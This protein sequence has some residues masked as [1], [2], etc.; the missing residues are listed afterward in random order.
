MFR[1]P[2]FPFGVVDISAQSALSPDENVM[3]VMCEILGKS[4]QAIS[5]VNWIRTRI[6][7]VIAGNPFAALK[8]CQI[9][10]L[11]HRPIRGNLG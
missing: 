5:A 1:S 7:Y 9:T 3:T 8:R 11:F 2:K 6:F 10:K 4:P